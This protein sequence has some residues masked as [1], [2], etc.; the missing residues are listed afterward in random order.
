MATDYINA[1]AGLLEGNTRASTA[2][3]DRQ[4]QRGMKNQELLQSSANAATEQQGTMDRTK[5]QGKQQELLATMRDQAAMALE[6]LQQQ[7]ASKRQQKLLEEQAAEH[8]QANYFTM[9]PN[10]VK[11]IKETMDLDFK[12]LEGQEVNKDVILALIGAKYKKD[13][14]DSILEGKKLTGATEKDLQKE[15]DKIELGIKGNRDKLFG[16][17]LKDLPDEVWQGG[18]KGDFKILLSNITSGHL[19]NIS[20]EAESQVKIAAGYINQMKSQQERANKIHKALNNTPTDYTGFG[21]GDEEKQTYKSA[22]EVQAAYKSGQL[23]RDAAKKILQEKFG[24]K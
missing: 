22:Q 13:I 19:G 17:S 23:S 12:S 5:V 14:A 2:N 21:L 15:L 24:L 3:Q 7:E 18:K 8:Y 11:G 4:A 20:P 16:M 6:N 9:T 1:A 10:T